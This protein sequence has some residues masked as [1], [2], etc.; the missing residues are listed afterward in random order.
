MARL[1]NIFLKID[2]YEEKKSKYYAKH[3]LESFS[4]NESS[5]FSTE[6]VQENLFS[7]A[8]DYD[9]L[10]ESLKFLNSVEK[11]IDEGFTDFV[12]KAATGAKNI[13]KK[14]ANAVVDAWTGPHV[15]AIKKWH[16]AINKLADKYQNITESKNP[17]FGNDY[18]IEETISTETKPS[19]ETISTETKPSEE[20]TSNETPKEETPKEETP[21]EETPKEETPNEETT[22]NETPNEETT[23]SEIKP[24][25][26]TPKEEPVKDNI[27]FIKKLLKLS[28]IMD[29]ADGFYERIGVN[30]SKVFGTAGNFFKFGARQQ[31]DFI[32]MMRN[33]SHKQQSFRPMTDKEAYAVFA[34]MT[35][36]LT[37]IKTKKL[38]PPDE[39]P[40]LFIPKFILPA[41][42]YTHVLNEVINRETL[43]FNDTPSQEKTKIN[44]VIP[45]GEEGG[46][47]P[48]P[49]VTTEVTPDI[50]LINKF[51][52]ENPTFVKKLK[53]M[54]DND[55]EILIKSI[56]TNG[57]MV[58]D[59]DAIIT[60]TDFLEDG[61]NIDKK[62]K[63]IK[64]LKDAGLD[65][66][67]ISSIIKYIVDEKLEDSFYT[68]ST[69]MDIN[70]IVQAMNSGGIITLADKIF[71]DTKL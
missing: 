67:K 63:Y 35:L 25:E 69:L 11:Q 47:N 12:K 21:K 9:T 46:T 3:L 5:T 34:N 4:L 10:D 39:D 48:Q 24:S 7:Q 58:K 44:P 22:S 62:I 54:S 32:S 40:K 56:E 31:Y 6:V 29:D 70:S 59:I 28:G 20:T 26:E 45:A 33:L 49:K 15:A 41:L 65:T 61:I 18:L 66:T 16:I 36:L 57:V 68:N 50:A 51:T 13:V 71:D 60:N 37:T 43:E 17:L 53:D 64:L 19:E 42:K 52:K 2:T 55:K 38:I 1:S 8:M 23:S 27:T 30:P 14:V